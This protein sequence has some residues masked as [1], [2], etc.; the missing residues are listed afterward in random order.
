[1]TVTTLVLVR[2]GETSW[3]A[4]S[5]IQGHADIPLNRLGVTQAKAVGKRL[6]RERFDAVYSSD[7]IRAF[8]TARPA[9]PD[10]DRT[11]IKD[12]RLRE[13]HLGVLQGLTGEEAMADQPAA[14]KAFKSR[15]PNL[16][17][18]GGERLGEFS[19]RVV[20]FVE[21]ILEAHAGEHVLVVTHGG[22]LDAAYRHAAGMPLSASRNFP[23][24]NASVN[25][26]SHDKQGW[27]IDA[28]GD[29]SH[30]PQELSMDDG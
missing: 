11:I 5:R 20:S 29:V 2:H 19:R 26:L 23:I 25:I 28:W 10:P 21:D 27:R 8:H 12:Q 18:A 17:L 15:D 22:V 24:Y 1:M 16:E 13:R 3:N 14:W 9:V 30:L 7:L 4:E 6:A